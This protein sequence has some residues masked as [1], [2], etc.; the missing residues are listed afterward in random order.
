MRG[1]GCV[2]LG[3]ELPVE[4][5]AGRLEILSLALAQE[6]VGLE[7]LSVSVE[8]FVVELAFGGDL[9]EQEE[10]QL[11]LRGR[12]RC[13]R[14]CDLDLLCACELLFDLVQGSLNELFALEVEVLVPRV[15]DRER[16]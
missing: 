3:V 16:D 14:V 12:G 1:R 7:S 10:L 4:G 8:D 2:I 15:A 11:R 6:L 5:T 13:V 9:V